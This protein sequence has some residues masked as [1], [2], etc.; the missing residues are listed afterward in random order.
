[1]YNKVLNS[2]K[3]QLYLSL[4]YIFFNWSLF[5]APAVPCGKIIYL[6]T[7]RW[8]HV[9]VHARSHSF[10]KNNHR[11][12]LTEP[13]MMATSPLFS[14]TLPPASSDLYRTSI[15]IH[16]LLCHYQ[17][18][19]ILIIA[20]ANQHHTLSTAAHLEPHQLHTH[21]MSQAYHITHGP[22]LKVMSFSRHKTFWGF[23]SALFGIHWS[24]SLFVR[25]SISLPYALWDT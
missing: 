23:E 6:Q 7:G 12:A 4:L 1:M 17:K 24:T 15:G 20:I 18:T 13:L 21:S 3:L 11:T 14:T 8:E 9:M 2:R 19:I 25:C 10:W 16:P 5:A 22:V